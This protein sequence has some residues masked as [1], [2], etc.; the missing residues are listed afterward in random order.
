MV[1][2]FIFIIKSKATPVEYENYDDYDSY[3]QDSENSYE[4][5]SYPDEGY[6]G[7][8]YDSHDNNYDFDSPLVS[9][10]VRF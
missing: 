9:S 8:E 3:N 2:L 6:S 7:Y 4:E 5:E 10:A 1:I